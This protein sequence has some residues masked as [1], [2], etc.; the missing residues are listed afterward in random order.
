[1]DMQSRTD[2]TDR[3]ELNDMKQKKKG[4]ELY[5][6]NKTDLTDRKELNDMKWKK[7]DKN[8]ACRIGLI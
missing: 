5:M 7:R 6:Q 8:Y 1:M 4:Q 2:L 3:K